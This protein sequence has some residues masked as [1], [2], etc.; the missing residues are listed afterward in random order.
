MDKQ[1]KISVI[2]TEYSTDV[3]KKTVTCKIYYK[4]KTSDHRKKQI[5]NALNA[6]LDGGMCVNNVYTAVATAKTLPGDEFD[7]HKG[8]QISRA[9]AESMAYNR[10]GSF[11]MRLHNW[12][13]E[14]VASSMVE[15]SKKCLD[16]VSHN[17][18]YIESF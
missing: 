6:F 9:K 17:N 14:N 16:V 5:I 12:Y 8:E 18:K 1:F 15:F 3:E 10:V 11:F 13:A 7:Q 4:I 2:E